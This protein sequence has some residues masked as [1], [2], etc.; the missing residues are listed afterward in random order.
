MSKTVRFRF[1]RAD[2]IALSIAVARRPWHFRVVTLV[3]SLSVMIFVMAWV[4]SDV[5]PARSMLSEVLAGD[6][7]WWPFLGFLVLFS[8]GMLFRHRLVGLNARV[9]YGR[10][11][12]ADREVEATLDDDGVHARAVDGAAF[13]WRFTWNDVTRLIETPERL[14]LATGYRQG[15]P[16]PRAAVAGD[17]DFAALADFVRARLPSG[18]PHER[19]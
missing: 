2:W 14:I 3:A 18:A 13:D 7:R 19:L 16:I 6:R 10:M 5:D 8:L 11:P 1:T 4:R 15:L 17:A 12:L 9:G